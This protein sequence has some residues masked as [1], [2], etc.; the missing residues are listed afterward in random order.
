MKFF[1]AIIQPYKL[2]VVRQARAAIGINGM[3]VT[4]VKGYGRQK[5][6]TEIYRGQEYE[7]N[8]MPKLK[9]EIG[10]D[11]ETAVL[12]VE[13]IRE[14]ACENRIGDGKIFVWDLESAMRIRTAES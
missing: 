12:A 14:K 2:E 6:Q 5:G 11:D 13:A 3:T 10:V 8:Y 1:T 4:E 7:I 9:L